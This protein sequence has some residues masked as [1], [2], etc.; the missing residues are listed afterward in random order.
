MKHPNQMKK[1]LMTQAVLL[2]LTAGASLNAMAADAAAADAADV[3]ADVA[4]ATP[5]AAVAD[6]VEAVIVTGTR[7]SGLKAVDSASPIQVLDSGS[8]ERTGQPDLIQ[9]L[10]GVVAWVAERA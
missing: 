6:N 7:R 10:A 1:R 2:A 3:A 9:A 4:A 5:P 8:L